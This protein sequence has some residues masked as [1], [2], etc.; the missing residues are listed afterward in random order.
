MARNTERPWNKIE[1]YKLIKHGL[2][3]TPLLMGNAHAAGTETYRF[4]L[5]AQPLS[6]TL[7]GV[8]QAAHTS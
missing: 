3:I 8:A 1:P 2:L 4:D 6:A 7:D 5:P